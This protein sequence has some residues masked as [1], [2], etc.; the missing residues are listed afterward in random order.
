MYKVFFKDRAIFLGDKTESL[1]F[2]GMVYLW[3]EGNS[4]EAIVTDFDQ[5][6]NKTA[7][8]FAAEDVEALFSEFKNQFK[9][10]EAAGGLV[11]N[12]ENEI[13]AIHR[14][15]RWD[16]PKGKVE[17]D[18]TISEA[19]IREVEEECGI[20]HL[21][22][23]EELEST[24]HTYW[25]NNSWVLKRSYWF[26]MSYSGNEKLV[27]QTEEDIEK[28]IWIPTNQLDEFKSNTY[29]SILEVLKNL[30]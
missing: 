13:L 20:S 26:K 4:L 3:T 1:N 18:E 14:L 11:F 19:A 30:A 22:L 15:G 10:I 12:Q 5:D 24:Y 28:V 7:L 2:H 17:E 23:K 9:Y 16:L 6:E 21:Q 29:A 25:M 27:P 8:F